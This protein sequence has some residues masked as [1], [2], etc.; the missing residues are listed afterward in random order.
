MPVEF[1]LDGEARIVRS[2][3]F[4]VV[5]HHEMYEHMDRVR[6]L[7]EDGTLDVTW[8]QI[9]DFSATERLEGASAERI[10][11]MAMSNPWPAGS[12]RAFITPTDL[13]FGLGRMYQLSGRDEGENLRIVRSLEEALAWIAGRRSTSAGTTLETT[14]EAP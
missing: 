6:E 14:T 4:G 10:R 8:A 2:R 9:A 7:F 11:S 3:A 12:L 13:L 5:T 1:E